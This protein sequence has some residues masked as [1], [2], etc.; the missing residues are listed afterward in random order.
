MQRFTES[1]E[2]FL[3]VQELIKTLSLYSVCLSEP[4]LSPSRA[5]E[6]AAPS[7]P[8]PRGSRA[9]LGLSRVTRC[10][11]AVLGRLVAALLSRLWVSWG[12]RAQSWELLP[13]QQAA[14]VST[15]PGLQA[16]GPTGGQGPARGMTHPR[17]W[18]RGCRAASAHSAVSAAPSPALCAPATDKPR[19]QGC[20]AVL[21]AILGLAALPFP[22]LT[23]AL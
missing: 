2:L 1:M 10:S 6:E 15:G 18:R 20:G 8:P 3:S 5:P 9:A 21:G 4:S 14:G 22:Y 11:H 13:E 23:A 16:A 7:C 17:A 12:P 19:G